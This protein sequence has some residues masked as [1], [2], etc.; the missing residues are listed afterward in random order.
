MKKL[1]ILALSLSILPN[2]LLAQT[3]DTLKDQQIKTI[4]VKSWQT[5]FRIADQIPEVHRTYL[6][7]G[8]K[9]ELISI[10][11][12][13][14]NVVEKT[15]RQ[16]F[17]K[18]PGAFAY[19]MDGSGN[20]LNLSLRGLDPHRSWDMNVRQN[21]VLLNSDLYGYPASHYNPPLES[22]ERI[23]L[24]RG[25][26]ALQYGAMFGGM[27]NYITRQPDTTKALSFE[28]QS[29]VGSYGLLSTYNALG[30]KIGRF[31]WSSY[32]YRRSSDGYRENG[33]S[34]SEAQFASL[35]WQLLKNL[36]LK[37]EIARSTYRYQLPGPLNDSMFHADP[38]QSTRSRNYY[39]PDILVPSLTLDWQL[40]SRS[41]VQWIASHLRG[42]RS[43]VQFIGT[44][45]R[46]D[47]FDSAT[48]TYK[49]R[50]VD[51]D[52]FNSSTAELRFTHQYRIGSMEAILAT[53]ARLIYND[54]NRLQLGKGTTGT[55]Y[56]LNRTDPNWGRDLHYKTNNAALFVEQ[57]LRISP[58]LSVSPGIRLESGITRMSGVLT[59]LPPDRAITEIEHRFALLGI[60]FQYNPRPNLRVYGGLSQAYRPVVLG[61]VIPANILEKVDDNLR[62]SRGYNAELGVQG[63]WF[64]KR[65][66]LHATLF[67]VQYNN[68]IGQQA[69][70][71]ASGSTYF[72]KT[73][74][75]DSRTNGLELYVEG[76]ALRTA[77]TYISLYTAT[78]LMD[79][80][81]QNGQIAQGN[82]NVD[83]SDKY[84]ESVPR[85][86]SRNGL[87]TSWK[88]WNA[89][90][91]YSFVAK[92]YADPLNTEIANP[93][94]ARGLVPAYS[95]WDAHVGVQINPNVRFR[96][97][98]NNIAN[99]QY[100]TKRPTIYPGPG[101]WPS[102]GRSI[103][104]MVTLR[105]SSY[106][107]GNLGGGNLQGY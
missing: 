5:P 92:T 73:N 68:R 97:S 83:L 56:D 95:L 105:P 49:P 48:G 91:Q 27:L 23:E 90:L 20:Q 88:R 104:G 71:D 85:L 70:E 31:T 18:I 12:T 53:G 59:T 106:R 87:Q 36:R 44:S 78:A 42:N 16:V 86:T 93:N 3:I 80:R 64:E 57:L 96:L 39:S 52:Y 13:P 37:G 77:S 55:D 11:A 24:V 19:D 63:D 25:T 94:G 89:A 6:L 2:G 76:V 34:S 50:Q 101:V 22:I 82:N 10:D 99:H 58:N 47:A 4:T 75:G 81:Y 43:S 72:L 69:L 67:Q 38:R 21:G 54:L 66:K 45:D 84:V 60:S 35:A 65:L 46:V 1:P 74:I 103:I 62:D 107:S 102:D 33:R 61:E 17:A 98:V 40:G 28:N 8:K 30:G 26:A 7:A 9:T 79:G 14:A 41:R 100:F 32:Y 29:A 15:V 51:I